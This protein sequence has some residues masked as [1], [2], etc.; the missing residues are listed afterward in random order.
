MRLVEQY[1]DKVLGAIRGLDRVYFR[2]T[3][4]WLA[5]EM[6]VNK[7]V[8]SQGILLKHFKRW[9]EGKTALLRGSCAAQAKALGVEMG[10]RDTPSEDKER[11]ARQIA[12]ER[13]VS[14]GTICMFSVVEPCFAPSVKGNRATG[15][16]ELRMR[17]RQCAWIYRYFDDPQWGFGHVRVQTWMPW[18]IHVC[19]N[20]RHALEKQLKA[21][22]IGYLKDGNCFPWIGDLEAAQRLLDA[23]LQTDW[24]AFLERLTVETCPQ[25]KQVIAPLDFPYYWSAD[26]TEWATDVMFKSARDLDALF[27]SLVRHAMAVS[28]SP[29]V[30]RYFGKRS[31][32]RSGRLKGRSAQEIMSDCRRRYEGVRVKHWINRN[33]IKAYNKSGSLLRL[34]T[35]INA[36]RDFKVFRPPDDDAGKPPS[37]QKLRKG[38]SDLHRRCQVSDQANERYGEALSAALANET[39]QAVAAEACN[40]VVKNGQRFRALN[41]WNKQDFQLLTFLARGELAINGFRNKDLR[42]W[43]EPNAQTLDQKQQRRLSARAS[44]AIRLLR[45]H[46]LI[47]KTPQVYRYALTDKG[48]KLA[49]AL[50]SASVIEIHKLLEM[51]A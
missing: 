25:L 26:E 33:A 11:L 24:P 17:R 48:R 19:L 7:F 38:V 29:S 9:A 43:L 22:R 34:E 44:R 37:W 10:Y 32:S 49:A 5:N 6:G 46:G 21:H 36:T 51:A 18:T 12:Q 13:Q 39:L 27:P 1:R 35:T 45:A 30:M 50:L 3:I 16:L 8:G 40:P 41:P 28:D 15:K 20:G 42:P 2:G 31:V 23:Q 4:R 14:E 47:R